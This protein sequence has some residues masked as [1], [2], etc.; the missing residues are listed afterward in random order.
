MFKRLIYDTGLDWVPI[1]AFV[2]TFAVFC[3]FVV[4]ALRMKKDDVEHMSVLP[5]EG[6]K[7]KAAKQKEFNHE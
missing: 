4:R 5:L 2:L 1:L 7:S 6:K 3:A